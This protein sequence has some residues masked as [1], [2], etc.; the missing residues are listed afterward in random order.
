MRFNLY[1]PCDDCPFLKCDKAIRLT[2]GRVKDISNAMLDS[3]GSSF[4]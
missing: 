4:A 1:K 2:Q 3:Q